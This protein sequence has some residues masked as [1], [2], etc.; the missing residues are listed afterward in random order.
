MTNLAIRPSD[1]RGVGGAD[2][3]ESRFSF[4]FADYHDPAHMGFRS[5]RVINEDVIAPSGGFPSHGHRDME[6]ITYVMEG[7][8]SHKDSLG[9]GATIRPGEIQRMSA[10]SGIMHSEFNASQSEKVHLLQIWILPEKRGGTPSYAQ[11]T[12]NEDSVS[13]KFGLI[14]SRDG[15]DRSISLQQDAN[16]WLAKLTKG[17]TADFSLAPNRGGWLQIARGAVIVDGQQ[18]EAGDGANWSDTDRVI[19]KATDNSEILIFDLA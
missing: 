5:L 13:G 11:Q 3:L 9:T 8:L 15:R 17:Q 14:A 12:I 10:G 4:S 16:L 6:I 1:E 18:L 2:W 7:A 19:L